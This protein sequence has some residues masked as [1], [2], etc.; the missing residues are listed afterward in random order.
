M[1]RST[2]RRSTPFT[3]ERIGGMDTREVLLP[4]VLKKGG[5][6]S[7]IFREVGFGVAAAVFFRWARGVRRVSMGFVNTGIDYYTH[8]RYGGGVDVPRQRVGPRRTRGRTARI[9]SAGRACGFLDT[10]QGRPVFSCTCRFNAPHSA[11]NLDSDIRS[12]AQAPERF[13]ADVPASERRCRG[14]SPGTANRRWWPR[15][16]RGVCGT[17]RRSRAWTRAIGGGA[18]TF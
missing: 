9:S 11:S 14:G 13:Q 3:F 18:R 8:E 6:R 4:A 12:G 16:R 1:G 15:A 10:N 5:Y 7:A 17:W 2:R